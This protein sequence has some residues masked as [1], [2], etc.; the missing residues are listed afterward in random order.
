MK[1]IYICTLEGTKVHKGQSFQGCIDSL[2]KLLLIRALIKAEH[3]LEFEARSTT[4][5]WTGV[6]EFNNCTDDRDITL[7][8]YK[9]EIY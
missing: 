7:R 2:N 4:R 5:E 8:V 1:T 9:S 3:R 6:Q